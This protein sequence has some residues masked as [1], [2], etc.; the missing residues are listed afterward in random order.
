MSAVAPVT[1]F[2]SRRDPAATRRKWVER[3]D[4]FRTAGQ[5]V[6][7]FCV[8]E[9]ISVPSFYVWKRT[10]AADNAVP[11]AVP[12]SAPTLRPHPTHTRHPRHP[13]NWSLPAAHSCGSPPTPDPR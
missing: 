13:S 10:L 4:R 8:A 9:G 5:T 7:Q 1:V 3:L 6:A 12:T 2:C 11:H